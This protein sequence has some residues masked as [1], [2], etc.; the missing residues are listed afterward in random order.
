MSRKPRIGDLLVFRPNYFVQEVLYTGI[1]TGIGLDKWGHQENV[2]I[3]WQAKKP[4]DYNDDY[5]YCGLNIINMRQNFRIIREGL[6]V[7]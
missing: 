4:G 7:E 2:Y 5:G 3:S 6:E 1:V